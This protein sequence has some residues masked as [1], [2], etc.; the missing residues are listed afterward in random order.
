MINP[1]IMFYCLYLCFLSTIMV[2]DLNNENI[3]S[4]Y[5]VSSN[6]IFFV[7]RLPFNLTFIPTFFTRISGKLFIL[8][9]PL[10][11]GFIF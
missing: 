7:P 5:L 1:N 8:S 10:K 6:Q 2:G 9:N 4:D 3:F 11:F